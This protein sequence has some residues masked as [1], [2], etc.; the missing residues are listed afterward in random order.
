MLRSLGRAATALAV[1]GAASVALAVPAQAAVPCPVGTYG[2]G[3]VCFIAGTVPLPVS[4]A[5]PG[6][7]IPFK[8]GGFKPGSHVIV[9]IHSVVQTLGEFDADSAGFISGTLEVPAGFSGAHSI[10]FSGV[11][12]SGKLRVISSPITVTASGSGAGASGG[13]SS[14]PLTGAEVAVA[15]MVGA[16]L[17]GAG[18]AT[19]FAG[20]KRRVAV[21]A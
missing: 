1:A 15:A 21:T 12:A 20:R 9:Q 17:L 18:G 10:T 8:L 4:E 7:G 6:Q 5:V 14:L 2:A 19:L 11:D 16:G 3:V 13:G